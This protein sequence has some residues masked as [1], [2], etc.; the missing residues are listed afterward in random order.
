MRRQCSMLALGSMR[1][2]EGAGRVSEAAPRRRN[3][4]RIS[5]FR[6]SLHGWPGLVAAC[7]LTILAILIFKQ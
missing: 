6:I 4:P 5:M 1:D 2:L 7:N 3:R